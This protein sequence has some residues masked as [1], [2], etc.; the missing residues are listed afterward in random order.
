MRNIILSAYFTQFPDPQRKY[1]WE[2]KMS[3]L[4]VLLSS[5]KEF[6]TVIFTDE[7]SSTSS[8]IV[9]IPRRTTCNPYIEKWKSCLSFLRDNQDIDFVWITDSTDTELLKNPFPYME[10]EIL[11]IGY[12]G[13]SVN[14][15]WMQQRHP[16]MREWLY[17]NRDKPRLMAGTVGGSRDI[18]IRLIVRILRAYEIFRSNETPL[19]LDMGPFNYAVHEYNLP[20]VTGSQICNEFKTYDRKGPG[21]WRHK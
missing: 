21:W 7:L 13:V 8:S 11:Y 3:D 9:K 6:E 4:E 20:Y 12:L 18:M 16:S 1:K 10:K 17:N 2:P 15:G 14:I 19:V 5:T